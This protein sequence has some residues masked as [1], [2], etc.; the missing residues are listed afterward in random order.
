MPPER[1]ALHGEQEVAAR[2]LIAAA[3]GMAIDAF[4]DRRVGEF[5]R[6]RQA[7]IDR[8]EGP[9]EPLRQI[10]ELFARESSPVDAVSLARWAFSARAF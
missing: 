7:A 10:V 9:R 1:H 5:R 4:E 8:V 2:D 6:A 3:A